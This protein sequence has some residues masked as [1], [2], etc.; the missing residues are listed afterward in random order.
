MII[1][2][3]HK[4]IFV[5]TVK[6]AGTSIEAFLSEH[7]GPNDVLTPVRPPVQG[8]KPRNYEGFAYPILD[9]FQKPF[10]PLSD[11]RHGFARRKKF[12][13]H[14]PAW[15]IQKRVTPQVWDNYFKF[16][17]ERNPWDKVLSHYHMHAARRGGSLTLDQYLAAGKFPINYVRYT[18]A[19]RRRIIVDRVVRYENLMSEL[20][21]VF[22]RINVP[23]EGTLGARAKSEYRADRTPYQSV[24]NENQR[25]IVEK[26]FAREIELHGYQF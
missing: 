7:C 19:S 5:K 4:F 13:P 15:R 10:G 18:D 20:A 16:C 14:M 26:A 22:A 12:Y 1:S 9:V 24:F 11:L 17:V 25:R 2:H 21:E 23:F 8:H 3:E 6:T